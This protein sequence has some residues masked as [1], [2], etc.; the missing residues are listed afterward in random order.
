M[1]AAGTRKDHHA[2]AF[3]RVEIESFQFVTTG[4]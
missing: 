1:P 2:I 3:F 4:S